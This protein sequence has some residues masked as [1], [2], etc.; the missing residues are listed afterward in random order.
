MTDKSD[1]RFDRWIRSIFDDNPPSPPADLEDSEKI[2]FIKRLFESFDAFMTIYPVSAVAAGLGRIIDPGGFEYL[3]ALT[4]DCL[5][6]GERISA[7]ESLNG[8]MRYFEIHCLPVASHNSANPRS[9][10]NEVCYCWW[11]RFPVF[12][13]LENPR[14]KGIEAAFLR[15]MATALKSSSPAVQE[16]ALHGLGH[17]HHDYPI[18]V[19]AAI[20]E[21]LKCNHSID[22]ILKSY[23]ASAREGMVR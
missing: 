12:P 6:E 1:P 20:E 23:A 4:D 14:R 9:P 2:N 15:H 5:P 21:Y 19:E 8:L 7:I 13:D 3:N 11:D 22:P 18:E 16:Y 10:L 17:W